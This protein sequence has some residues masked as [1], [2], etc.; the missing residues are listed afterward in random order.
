MDSVPRNTILAG[1]VLDRLRG[2][3]DGCVQTVVTSP[4]YWGLRD[5]GVPGQIGLEPTPAAYVARMVEVFREVRRVLRSDGTCWVNLGDSY[6]SAWPAPNTRRNI[7]GNPMSGGKRGPQRQSKL[8]DA[9][10][11]KDLIGMPWRVAFALQ[12]DGWYLRSDI[13]WNKPNPMPE[14]VTDR[15]TKSHEYIFLLSKRATYYYDADAVREPQVEPDRGRNPIALRG[16]TGGSGGLVSGRN[17][18]FREMDQD[19][20]KRVYNPAGRNK[21]SVWTVATEAYPDAHFATFPRKLIEPCILAGSSPQ[22]CETCGAPWRRVVEAIGGTIGKS[23]HDHNDDLGAGQRVA[24]NGLTRVGDAPGYARIERGWR[25]SCR[26]EVNTGAARS[27]VLD[28]FMGSG[29]VALVARS[30]QRDYL[31]I[32]LNPAYIEMAQRRLSTVA[33]RLFADGGAA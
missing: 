26:C 5:Y 13:I 6:A 29:T 3:P 20:A 16:G 8:A 2:L 27:L 1:D 33:V 21:R 14:S 30:W 22:A 7:I 4:P 10:K 11:E 17:A 19:G 32:E 25:P 28:P 31:G 12:A 24:L 9:L 18:A 23:W 15:P